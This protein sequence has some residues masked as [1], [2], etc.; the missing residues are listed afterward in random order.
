MTSDPYTREMRRLAVIGVGLFVLWLGFLLYLH[1]TG[2]NVKSA[3]YSF[4]G[5]FVGSWIINRIV[6]RPRV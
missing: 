3:V 4:A 5:A 2:G 6:L 1:L